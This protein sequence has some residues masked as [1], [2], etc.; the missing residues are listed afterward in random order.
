MKRLLTNILI[1]LILTILILMSYSFIDKKLGGDGLDS[2]FHIENRNKERYHG[3]W[4]SYL[5]FVSFMYSTE[6]N[7]EKEFEE[8]YQHIL[9]RL[10]K[11]DINHIIVQVRPFGDAVY[12]SEYFPWASCISG[13]QGVSP[14]Y[15]PLK[16][17]VKLTHR[18]NMKIE[19]WINPYRVSFGD[20]VEDLS[21]DNQARI[22]RGESA[23]ERNVLTYNGSLY[24]N[25]SSQQ[26]RDLI[27]S[28]I[29]EI[30]KNYDV[31]GIHMDD[32]FYP[33]FT[34]NDYMTAFDAPEY[35][36]GIKN[37]NIPQD[38][39]LPDW[40]RDNV[41]LLVS[42]I[43]KK[44]KNIRPSVTFGI[45]PA[46]NP[47]YLRDNTAYYTDIDTW[48]SKK[49]YID[50]IMPQIYWGYTNKVSPFNELLQEWKELCKH[51]R[52]KLYAG[53]QLYRMGTEDDSS[54][55]YEELQSSEVI[56][57]QVEQVS[58]DRAI[59]GYCFFSYQYLDSGNED[60][61]FEASEFTE[62]RK[63][64]LKEVEDFLIENKS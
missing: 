10:K 43:Y 60:Y 64:I 56:I 37:G 7:N 47:E 38:L 58:K 30:V 11:M 49:G 18:N 48:L 12:D 61:Y 21:E 57:K 39:S 5:E 42:D 36:E 22:W 4:L 63:K 20:S 19:A 33:E 14:G 51:S 8:F 40:R 17:M 31:D 16:I 29:E 46:G 15:D 59:S 25:P 9:D 41:N 26:V 55:D 34:E 28:G 52:V 32:Y 54:S 50:Y 27:S 1:I 3:V 62:K 13:E 45:S 23:T 44:I 24:Y 35:N 2:F 53:L 6:S